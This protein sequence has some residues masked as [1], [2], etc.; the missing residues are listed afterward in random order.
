M[1]SVKIRA[2]L[3]NQR[4]RKICVNTDSKIGP[5]RG[6]RLCQRKKDASGIYEQDIYGH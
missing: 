2:C 6:I 3:M 5:W 4:P 1:L